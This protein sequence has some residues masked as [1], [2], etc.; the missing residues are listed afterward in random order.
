MVDQVDISVVISTYNWCDRLSNALES[1]FTQKAEEVWYE[2]NIRKFSLAA[3]CR[4]ADP[5]HLSA[6]H[7]FRSWAE[8]RWLL[9]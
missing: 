6:P 4:T 8:R 7:M 1:L 2:V 5:S 9:L 3:R